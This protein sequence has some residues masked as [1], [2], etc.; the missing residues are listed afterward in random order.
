ME[1]QTC[2]PDADQCH[3]V[4]VASKLVGGRL[5][6]AELL[7]VERSA[8]GNWK[9]RGIPAQHCQAMVR[10]TNGA[11]NLKQLRPND[12]QDFWPE[13]DDAKG[14]V[15]AQAPLPAQGDGSPSAACGATQEA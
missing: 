10:L 4:D 3:P 9:V 1:H 12:W 2:V 14:P 6:L 15:N 5:K 13:L 8:I 7:G 11:V